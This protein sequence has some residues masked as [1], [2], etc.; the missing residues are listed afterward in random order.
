MLLDCDGYAIILLLLWYFFGYICHRLLAEDVY[1]PLILVVYFY[2]P[3][4]GYS[5]LILLF[6]IFNKKRRR[7]RNI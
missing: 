4:L 2:H 3:V 5:L 1:C 6:R 7:R